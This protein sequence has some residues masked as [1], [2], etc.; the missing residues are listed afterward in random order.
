MST[1]TLEFF[2]REAANKGK[3]NEKDEGNAGVGSGAGAGAG[4]GAAAGVKEGV[5]EDD[6]KGEQELH[7]TLRAKDKDEL[8]DPNDRKV[9]RKQNMILEEMLEFLPKSNRPNGYFR[10]FSTEEMKERI[11]NFENG[12]KEKEG[13][14]PEFTRKVGNLNK[15]NSIFGRATTKF[16]GKSIQKPYQHV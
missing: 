1:G 3:G 16:F 12:K 9:K 4:A 2:R 10:Q 14:I 15:E 7:C 5:K 8:A 6:K 13:S 11:E